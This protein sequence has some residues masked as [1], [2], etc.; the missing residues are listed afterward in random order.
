[1]CAEGGSVTLLSSVTEHR[2]EGGGGKL[3]TGAPGE[4][5]DSG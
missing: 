3:E 4:T 1:M 2:V 5:A